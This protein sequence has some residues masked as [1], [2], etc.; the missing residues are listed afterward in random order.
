M[1]T[2]T[3]ELHISVSGLPPAKSEALSMFSPKHR[4][5]NRLI[6]LRIAARDSMQEVGFAPFSCLDRLVL[7]VVISCPVGEAWDATNY[8]G[9]IA[10]A[11]QPPP[12][13][14]RELGHLGDLANL[15]VYP[16][17]RMIHRIH[18]ELVDTSPTTY[19]VQLS[20]L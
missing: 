18:Y 16:D 4:D 6:A 8:L 1:Y 14:A 17:D 19:E 20:T 10:D 2:S 9:G 13:G 12:P 15:M 3:P 7:K 11:L 5:R